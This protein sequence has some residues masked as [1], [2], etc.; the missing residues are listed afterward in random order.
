MDIKDK[1]DFVMFWGGTYSQWCPSIFEID[2]VVYNTAEQYMMAKKAL[3][4]G[5]YD[6]LKKIMLEE[7]PSV[8]KALGKMFKE[9]LSTGDRE[10]VEAS[11]ED[12][13]WGIG[14]HE[15]NPLAWN[16]TTWR[17]TNWLGLAIMQVR[18]TLKIESNGY[19]K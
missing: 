5:D 6:S 2:G 16:K 9:L 4:F 7:S 12:N 3:L 18:E 10:I 1:P 17:G 13:I 8:Q 14:L 19:G 15:T 11:P